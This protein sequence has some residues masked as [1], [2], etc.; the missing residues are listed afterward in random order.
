MFLRIN[1]SGNDEIVFMAMDFIPGGTNIR[2]TDAGWTGSAFYANEGHISWAS[3]AGGIAG[4][5]IVTLTAGNTTGFTSSGAL[6]A[7]SSAS[8][9][10]LSWF[11][12]T[13][14]NNFALRI[15]CTPQGEQVLAYTGTVASPVFIS[16]IY[17]YASSG[18]WGY[19][20]VNAS[21][22]TN[23]PTGLTFAYVLI[24]TACNP[25]VQIDCSL[26]PEPPA[27]SDFFSAANWTS[28]TTAYTGTISTDCND[29]ILP[30]SLL[31]FT[32]LTYNETIILKWT[33]STELNSD[34]FII[35][36]SNDMYAFE[37]IGNINAA[38]NSNNIQEYM[39][40]DDAPHTGINYYRLKQVDINGDYTYS[41]I[42]YQK[43]N[44]GPNSFH[45][46]PNP[47]SSSLNISG[48]IF[49]PSAVLRIINT[50]GEIVF[51]SL[52]LTDN[53]S[54]SHLPDGIYILQIQNTISAQNISFIK[55]E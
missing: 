23:I 43:I 44:D 26:L 6:V 27:S 3:P 36:R 45:V 33:T 14:T 29:I 54:I 22:T 35:E 47:V 7:G 39:F 48:N 32:A 30:I 2:F 12:G 42:V 38:V 49:S 51:E 10:T 5:T 46:F 52:Y 13:G 16:A 4:G 34:H 9:G 19:S 15:S 17:Y 1:G 8:T 18:L 24:G 50:Q 25:N 37:S 31:Q 21:S 28:S 41:D 11:A 55:S 53:I 40:T 20:A